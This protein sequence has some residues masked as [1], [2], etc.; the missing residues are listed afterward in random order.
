M[1]FSVRASKLN[2]KRPC[3]ENEDYFLIGWM[4]V[5]N[6]WLKSFEVTQLKAFP[7]KAKD[8]ILQRLWA[9]VI[10]REYD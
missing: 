7:E 5:S 4:N 8:E 1:I 9:T 6:E 10:S 2:L 3:S